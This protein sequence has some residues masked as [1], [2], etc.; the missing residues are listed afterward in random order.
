MGNVAGMLV[1]A[2]EAVAGF[3]WIAEGPGLGIA[4]ESKC[5]D[6][7]LVKIAQILRES[8]EFQRSGGLRR[9]RAFTMG[10]IGEAGQLASLAGFRVLLRRKPDG[11]RDLRRSGYGIPHARSMSRDAALFTAAAKVQP[12]STATS[13]AALLAARISSEEARMHRTEPSRRR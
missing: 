3:G 9:E 8:G 10:A 6:K 13:F 4:K 1:V 11:Q 7:R 12:D 2:Y 5:E